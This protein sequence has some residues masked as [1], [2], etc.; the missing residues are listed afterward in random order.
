MEKKNTR[1]YLLKGISDL[2]TKDTT[3]ILN[4]IEGKKYG[5]GIQA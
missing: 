4:V 2:S 1:D 5:E 3:K